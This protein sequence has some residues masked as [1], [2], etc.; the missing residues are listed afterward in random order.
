MGKK[1]LQLAERAFAIGAT[2]SFEYQ[3]IRTGPSHSPTVPTTKITIPAI[4]EEGVCDTPIRKCQLPG[5]AHRA[6]TGR[7]LTRG[8]TKK[9]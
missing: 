8:I 6:T 4:G 2:E 3:F 9:G 7:L 1:R 5:T